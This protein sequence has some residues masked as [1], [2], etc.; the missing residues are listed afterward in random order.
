MQYAILGGLFTLAYMLN[1]MFSTLAPLHA[2]VVYVVLSLSFVLI[3]SNRILI[4]DAPFYEAAWQAGDVEAF[5]SVFMVILSKVVGFLDFVQLNASVNFIL[6]MLLVSICKSF[7][8]SGLENMVMAYFVG[9]FSFLTSIFELFKESLSF[10][11]IFMMIVDLLN[12]RRKRALIWAVLAATCHP[13]SVVM[14]A[15]F[16]IASCI[17]PTFRLRILA[18]WLVAV[19]AFKSIVISALIGG[20]YSDLFR[21]Y[22]EGSGNIYHLQPVQFVILLGSVLWIYLRERRN[23]AI[24]NFAFWCLFMN[25]T[26]FIFTYDYPDMARRFIYRMDILT[27]PVVLAYLMSLNRTYWLGVSI[28]ILSLCFGLLLMNPN[29]ELIAQF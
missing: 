23:P 20:E 14:T 8:Q 6:I 17:Q 26:I 16:Y 22:V 10:I 13:Y 25:A 19:Y 21:F 12:W 2:R 15:L 9:S 3:T 27:I 11:F 18:L 28:S 29:L 7:G 24:S 5:R 4:G 1:Y